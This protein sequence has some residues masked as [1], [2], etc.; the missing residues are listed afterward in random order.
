MDEINDHPRG[1]RECLHTY[2]SFCALMTSAFIP[3]EVLFDQTWG[4]ILGWIT[5]PASSPQ[6][7][8]WLHPI[9]LFDSSGCSILRLVLFFHPKDLLPQV[10]HIALPPAAL[11]T[12]RQVEISTLKEKGFE[13]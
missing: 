7:A 2:G 11:E 5:L 4:N 1:G 8:V 13:G 12:Q 6:E 10:S 9:I 3:T